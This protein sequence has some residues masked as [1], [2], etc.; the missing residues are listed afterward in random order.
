MTTGGGV[1][2][3]GYDED[4]ELGNSDGGT[5][6]SQVPEQVTGLTS[7]VTALS[8]G[9]GSA[10]AVVTCGGV[11]CWGGFPATSR[12]PAAVPLLGTSSCP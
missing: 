5:S 4:G 8:A 7:G 12:V 11:D 9:A 3:W 1:F 10:C 6:Q 2:C